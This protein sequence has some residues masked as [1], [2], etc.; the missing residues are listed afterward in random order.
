MIT[1]KRINLKPLVYLEKT[2]SQALK[3]FQQMNRDNTVLRTL[4]ILVAHEV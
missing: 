1:E 4:F 2:S 3:M